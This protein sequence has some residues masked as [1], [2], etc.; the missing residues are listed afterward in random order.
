M[1]SFGPVW[2]VGPILS[3]LLEE[4]LSVGILLFGP[5]IPI[6]DDQ[7]HLY[8]PP[9]VGKGPIRPTPFIVFD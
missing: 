2:K 9:E 4:E 3:V 7:H 8:I 5:M 6:T 1:S